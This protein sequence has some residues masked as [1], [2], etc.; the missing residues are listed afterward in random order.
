MRGCVAVLV[1]MMVLVPWANG[2][3]QEGDAEIA[4]PVDSSP[5]RQEP[6]TA[7]ERDAVLEQGK[8]EKMK[9]GRPGGE[10]HDGKYHEK[11][12]NKGK[13]KKKGQSQFGETGH[14]HQR[15]LDQADEVA[16]K[17]GHHGRAKARSRHNQK[18]EQ[19]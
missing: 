13:G 1:I 4:A 12:K 18:H 9:R 5:A 19:G 2:K 3:A 15:G 17:H 16:G 8:E 10:G 14:R 7:S 11:E 6:A